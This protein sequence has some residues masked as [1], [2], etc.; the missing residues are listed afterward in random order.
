ME[1][2][3][4][5]IEILNKKSSSYTGKDGKEHEISKVTFG[6]GENAVVGELTVRKEAYDMMEKGQKYSLYGEYIVGKSGNYISWLSAKPA[7]NSKVTIENQRFLEVK[8]TV[9]VLKKKVSTYSGRDGSAKLGYRLV[10]SQQDN[11]TVGELNIR[12]DIYDLVER[13]KE[14]DIYGEYVTTRTGNYITWSTA[15]P[16]S[17]NSKTIL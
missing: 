12:Q 11:D 9:K 3:T 2:I 5:A 7:S 14:Y 8:A 13:D 10:Y 1:V 6:Q 17:N 16:I 15:Q 4:N